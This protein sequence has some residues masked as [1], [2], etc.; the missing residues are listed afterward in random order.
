MPA[1]AYAAELRL[2]ESE[3][4]CLPDR[5]TAA[6]AFADAM[7]VV[8][9]ATLADVLE[10]IGQPSTPFDRYQE[11]PPLWFDVVRFLNDEF[12]N[13]FVGAH[14]IYKTPAPIEEDA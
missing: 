5:A 14:G 2:S 11:L 4:L 3:G 1:V 10:R 13:E 7:A 9:C 12:D 8:G 6:E